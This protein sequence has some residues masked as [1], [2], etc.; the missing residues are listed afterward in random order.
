MTSNTQKLIDIAFEIALTMKQNIDWV[1]KSTDEDITQ[2][3]S[4]QLSECGYQTIPLGISYGILKKSG[5]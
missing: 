4:K 1:E 3:V 5:K 2:W